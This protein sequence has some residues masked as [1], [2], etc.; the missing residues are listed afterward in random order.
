MC[1]LPEKQFILSQNAATAVF[2]AARRIL[3]AE[4]FNGLVFRFPDVSPET[5]SAVFLES[6]FDG[7]F[8]TLV[9]RR[10]DHKSVDKLLQRFQD[11]VS[12]LFVW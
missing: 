5:G 3:E 1:D 6:A 8:R 9:A 12:Q 7:I 11:N 2:D 10:P 4:H